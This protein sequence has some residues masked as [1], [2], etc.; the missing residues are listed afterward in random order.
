MGFYDSKYGVYNLSGRSKDM[1]IR[2]GENI[3]PTEIEDF[4]SGHPGIDDIYVVGV[5]SKRLGEEVCAYIRA[6]Q[7]LWF[8]L[9]TYSLQLSDKSL[10]VDALKEHGIT[11]LAKFKVPKYIAFVDE[12]PMTVTGK[13]KK[14]ELREQA[15]VD[16]PH[17]K[18]EIE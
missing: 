11:G 7:Q 8:K 14:F 13:V 10:T 3:Q 18:A 2:G 17:L 15:L 9:I 5:P 16:F 12:F 4:Y 1:I 6:S